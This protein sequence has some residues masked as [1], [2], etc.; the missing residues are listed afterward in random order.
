M[1]QNKVTVTI[2]EELRLVICEVIALR[3]VQ[4]GLGVY[5]SLYG[6][7]RKNQIARITEPLLIEKCLKNEERMAILRARSTLL[8]KGMSDNFII[9]LCKEVMDACNYS[10]YTKIDA[11]IL[12]RMVNL[13]IYGHTPNEDRERRKSLNEEEELNALR[14]Y[15]KKWDTDKEHQR[16]L[17]IK[18]HSLRSYSSVDINNKMMIDVK[19]LVLIEKYDHLL[20]PLSEDSIL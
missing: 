2:D 5:G 18:E 15:S 4:R 6:E 12:N 10:M 8:K 9:Q 20:L 7:S 1:N 3:E 17:R 11:S 16:M 13:E 14:E 19:C